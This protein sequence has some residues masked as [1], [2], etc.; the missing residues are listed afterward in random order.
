MPDLRGH[1]LSLYTNLKEIKLIQGTF[2]SPEIRTSI[3]KRLSKL[4]HQEM[5]FHSYIS[6]TRTT[7]KPA[8]VHHLNL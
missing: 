2:G 4:G 3:W 6:F 7:G 8:D 1:A 5:L